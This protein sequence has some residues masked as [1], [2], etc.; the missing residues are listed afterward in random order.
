[1]ALVMLLQ[2]IKL[3]FNHCASR[4]YTTVLLVTEL[5]YWV[6]QGGG[7]FSRLSYSLL[8]VL[9]SNCCFGH[10]AASCFLKVFAVLFHCT[11][12]LCLHSGRVLFIDLK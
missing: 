1:M 2:N 4:L 8:Y 3:Q 9:Q 11:Y 7:W 12:F 5:P 6:W 10:T